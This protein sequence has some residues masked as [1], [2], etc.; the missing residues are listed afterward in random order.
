M[1]YKFTYDELAPIFALE[2]KD[3]EKALKLNFKGMGKG[4]TEEEYQELKAL[5]FKGIDILEG[6]NKK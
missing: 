6:R 4:I 5:Y 3:H 2:E 1:L